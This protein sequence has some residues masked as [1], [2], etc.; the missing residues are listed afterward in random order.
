MK[1]R[2]YTAEEVIEKIVKGWETYEELQEIYEFV[3]GCNMTKEEQ[4]K[5]EESGWADVVYH[6]Y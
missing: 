6:E 4:E 2:F 3:D 5:L 1:G